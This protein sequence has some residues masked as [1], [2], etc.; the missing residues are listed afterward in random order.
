MS[1]PLCPCT[2]AVTNTVHCNY[3]SVTV[4]LNVYLTLFTCILN[5]S[6]TSQQTRISKKLK[7]RIIERLESRFSWIYGIQAKSSQ[8]SRFSTTTG[9]QV[10]REIDRENQQ[11]ERNNFKG[12]LLSRIEQ[13][14]ETCL[15]TS[16][17]YE[18]Q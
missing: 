9:I 10:D 6:N 15:P 17:D 14:T 18:T 4:Q 8:A 13:I 11:Y 7:H 2:K 5:S 12:P 3:T 1:P 16:I